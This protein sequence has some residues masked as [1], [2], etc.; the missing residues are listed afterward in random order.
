[1]I[2]IIVLEA[3]GL[4][5]A[6][7]LMAR[8]RGRKLRNLLAD[9]RS[10]LDRQIAAT[11]R[12]RAATITTPPPS[13]PAPLHPDDRVR[14]TVALNTLSA[15]DATDILLVTRYTLDRAEPGSALHEAAGR[16]RAIGERA[17][18]NL[19]IAPQ[20]HGPGWVR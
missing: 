1:L 9:V 11:V 3:A 20:L 14:T 7:W 6:C 4:L 19:G 17:A 2:T 16:A 15:L 5:L 10:R 13:S 18:D 12:A 8:W